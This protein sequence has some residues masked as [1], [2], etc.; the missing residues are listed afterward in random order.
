MIQQ[1]EE[2]AMGTR[3]S[4]AFQ[5]FNRCTIK[6]FELNILIK[7]M[8]ILPKQPNWKYIDKRTIYTTKITT[9]PMDNGAETH[10]SDF[11][12]LIDI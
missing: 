3:Q 11:Q 8:K 5:R 4:S 10:F 12:L 6:S 1:E 2:A 9:S 7:R